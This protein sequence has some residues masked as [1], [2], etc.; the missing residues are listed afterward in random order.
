VARRV[1]EGW[2]LAAVTRIQSGSPAFLRSS[3]QTFNASGGTGTGQSTTADAGVVLHGLTTSQL[4]DLMSIRKDPSGVVY[5]LP[6]DLLQN[7]YAAFEING[8]SL[9]NL[10]PN[11][12]YIGPPTTPGQMGQRIYLYGPWQQFWNLGVVKKTKIGEKKDIEFR[13]SFQNA[14][15]NANL[16]LAGAGNDVNTLNVAATGT[17]AF[18]QTRSAYRDFTVSGTNDPGGRAIEFTLRFNF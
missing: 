10:D 11:K 6:P 16:L 4:Q 3:R 17:P 18:G 14:F 5:Y 9:S 1:F 15:N 7:T 12:P 8:Q 13:A 2:E